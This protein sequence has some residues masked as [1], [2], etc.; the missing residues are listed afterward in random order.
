M[1]FRD[2]FHHT[3]L[4]RLEEKQPAYTNL[5]KITI[6]DR[7]MIDSESKEPF[8]TPNVKEKKERTD[9]GIEKIELEE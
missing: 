1:V 6:Q 4:Q 8:I 3:V 9:E 5:E 2:K 7:N